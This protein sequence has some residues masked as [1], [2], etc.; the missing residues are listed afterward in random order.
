[1]NPTPVLSTTVAYHL[2]NTKSCDSEVAATTLFERHDTEDNAGCAD[3]EGCLNAEEL[4]KM[5]YE[6]DY[7]LGTPDEHKMPGGRA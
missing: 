7:T 5:L 1:M 4:S 6:M 2:N 3:V